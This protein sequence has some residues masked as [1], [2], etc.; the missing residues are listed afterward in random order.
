[1]D[2]VLKSYLLAFIP[3]CVAFDV[4]GLIPMFM[5]FTEDLDHAEKTKAIGLAMITA[6]IVSVGFVFIGK[7]ILL[8]LGIQVS[9]FLVAGGILLF[10]I[11]INDILK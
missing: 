9:D 1:M 2:P 10:I 6:L 5:F 8:I 4:L 11:A 3:I 7:G